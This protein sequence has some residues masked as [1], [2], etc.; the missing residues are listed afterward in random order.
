MLEEEIVHWSKKEET[1]IRRSLR[2]E[3]YSPKMERGFPKDGY[4][5]IK[6]SKN[7]EKL[8][9]RLSPEEALRVGTQLISISKEL[10]NKKRKLYN[11]YSKTIKLSTIKEVEVAKR[12]K[13]ALENPLI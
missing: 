4:I 12:R 7:E 2:I 5:F 13:E 9:I 6:I 10:L 3:S 1:L 11:S 8:S